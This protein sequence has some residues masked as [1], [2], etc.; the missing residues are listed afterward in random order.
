MATKT[1]RPVGSIRS[2]GESVF[3]LA[4]AQAKRLKGLMKAHLAQSQRPASGTAKQKAPAKRRGA[5]A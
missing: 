2:A 5:A 1:N 3:D 4:P